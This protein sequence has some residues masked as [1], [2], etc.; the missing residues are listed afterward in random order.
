MNIFNIGGYVLHFTPL[1]EMRK[2]TTCYLVHNVR[3]GVQT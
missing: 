2:S 3:G 1:I